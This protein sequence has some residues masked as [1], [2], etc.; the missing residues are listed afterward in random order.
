[1]KLFRRAKD[2]NLL[3]RKLTIVSQIHQNNRALINLKGKNYTEV[4]KG[5][6]ANACASQGKGNSHL[7]KNE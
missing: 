7:S 5:Y 2:R 6:E 1:M 4:N 3:E